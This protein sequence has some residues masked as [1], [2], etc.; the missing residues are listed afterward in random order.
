MGVIEFIRLEV[1]GKSPQIL[2]NLPW[3]A[4][5]CARFQAWAKKALK[6]YY[7]A[8]SLEPKPGFGKLR[9]GPLIPEGIQLLGDD[10][11]EL[12]RYTLYDLDSARQKEAAP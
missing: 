2:G 1:G 11:F 7:E 4:T 3:A 8:N 9:G 5:D 6:G 12:S 10:G